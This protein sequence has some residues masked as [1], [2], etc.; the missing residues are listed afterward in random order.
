MQV[1]W[2]VE[3]TEHHRLV[4]I[5]ADAADAGQN[6]FVA[7]GRRSDNG[8][9]EPARPSSRTRPPS[10]S[11]RMAAPRTGVEWRGRPLTSIRTIINLI[12]ATTTQTGLNVTATDDPTWYHK[13]VEIADLQ[14]DALHFHR[15]EWHGDWNYTFTAKPAAT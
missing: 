7:S 3:I 4:R 8:R 5:A 2:F 10:R 12:S 1:E 13:G 6:A 15:H 9:T 11:P 14:M